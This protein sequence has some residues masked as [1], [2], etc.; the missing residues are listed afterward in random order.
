MFAN[1][2]L[3]NRAFSHLNK[4]RYLKNSHENFS[5]QFLRTLILLDKFD[6]AFIFSKNAAQGDRNFFESSLL[7]GLN[8]IVNENYQNAEK[9]FSKMNEDL[10]YYLLFEDFLRYVLLSWSQALQ[11]NMQQ[12]FFYYDKIPNIYNNLKKIQYSLLQCYFD[13]PN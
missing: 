10:D 3:S 9:H 7:M 11:N 13:K 5:I 12:S 1:Q 2:D 6:Q 8:D 4:I